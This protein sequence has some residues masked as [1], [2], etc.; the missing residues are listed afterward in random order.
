LFSPRA[1][2]KHFWRFGEIGECEINDQRERVNLR[3]LV[4]FFGKKRK[5]DFIDGKSEL[6]F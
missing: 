3:V 6:I 2:T 1:S 5:G 4:G